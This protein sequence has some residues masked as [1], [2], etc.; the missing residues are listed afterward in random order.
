MSDGKKKIQKSI[1]T[2]NLFN[3]YEL[4]VHNKFFK[5][6]TCLIHLSS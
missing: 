6:N 3:V 1:T 4:I 2:G 5:L